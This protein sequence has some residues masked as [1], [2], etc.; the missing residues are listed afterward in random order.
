MQESDHKFFYL[1]ILAILFLIILGCF[2]EKT[3]ILD[4][5]LDSHSEIVFVG[6]LQKLSAEDLERV[7]KEAL[8]GI[9]LVSAIFSLDKPSKMRIRFVD[10][11]ISTYEVGIVVLPIYQIR[12]NEAAIVHEVTHVLAKH[13]D[14]RFFSEGLAVYF[15]QRFGQDKCFPNFG[16]PLHEHLR[17]FSKFIMPIDKIAKNNDIFRPQAD[18]E[19]RRIA[20]VQ[21]GSF[22]QW[23][24]EMHG[25]EKLKELH[26]SIWLDYDRIYGK[27]LKELGKEWK[28]FVFKKSSTK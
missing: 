28:A 5:S 4:T 10:Y 17:Y 14:N 20:Y 21:A 8:K 22:I 7:R 16:E 13:A 11:G 15:Q 3:N 19:T 24:V 23:L 27:S 26:D 12:R 2:A 1:G 25:E 18:H 9:N 6:K